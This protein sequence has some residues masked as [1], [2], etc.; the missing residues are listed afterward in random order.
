MHRNNLYN[1]T[2]L[3]AVILLLLPGEANKK[4]QKVKA[5]DWTMLQSIRTK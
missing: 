2:V 4:K 3:Y 5:K 1:G